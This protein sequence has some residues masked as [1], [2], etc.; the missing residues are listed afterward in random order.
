MAIRLSLTNAQ[1][2]A[3]CRQSFALFNAEAFAALNPGI[4][5][6]MAP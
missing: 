5:L 4:P 1:R 2:A 3:L 6:Q